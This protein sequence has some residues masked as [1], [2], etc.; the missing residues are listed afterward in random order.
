[1]VNFSVFN[2]LSLPLRDIKEFEY[3]FKV[4]RELKSFGLEK[5]R[6][7]REFTKYS[8]ILPNK[9]FQQLIGE[10]PVSDRDKKRRLLS[11]IKNGI[12][13]IESPLIMSDEDEKEQ[14]LENE[15][16]YKNVSTKGGLACCDIWNTISISFNSKDEW[17]NKTV[18]LRKETISY[19]KDIDIRHASIVEHLYTHQDF[20]EELE[21]DKKL[22]I[23]QNNFWEKRE[24]LFPEKIIFCKELEK[25]IK[26]LDKTIFQQAIAILRDIETDKKLITDYNYS[27]ESQSVKN[28]TELKKHRYFTINSKKVYFDNHIKS[29]SNAN[30]IYFLEQDNKIYIGYIG[31]H[32]PTQKFK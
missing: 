16:F 10:I 18:I 7:D 12:A 19:E 22:G 23:T 1:M 8:E 2:E 17:N 15:Y 24:E 32:L 31:K 13:V 27:R 6:M 25:Q 4:L 28:D 26:K 30:R 20:F 3:F 29:L 21:K 9:T 5:I 11:F 14:L